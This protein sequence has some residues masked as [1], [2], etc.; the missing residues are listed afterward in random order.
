MSQQTIQIELDKENK[1]LSRIAAQHDAMP[2]HQMKRLEVA[3]RSLELGLARVYGNR[4]NAGVAQRI[5][6]SMVLN[7][8]C[9]CS[10]GG[11]VNE[12]PTTP[13]GWDGY[14]RTLAKEEPLAQ[15]S[16]DHSDAQLKSELRAEAEANMR[17]DDRIKMARAGTLDVHLADIV[18]SRLEA[19][20]GVQ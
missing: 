3:Q 6:D 16:I 18:A 8:A 15:L 7:P 13:A 17:P 11:G 1:R 5:I 10:V 20:A 4:L 9:L 2:P 14:A 12:L 19:R